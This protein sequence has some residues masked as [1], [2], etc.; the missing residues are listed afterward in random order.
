LA[1]GTYII[2]EAVVTKVATYILTVLMICLIFRMLLR[3]LSGVHVEV[4]T[5]VLLHV[6]KLE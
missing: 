1:A 2:G 6:V 4:R 5:D 3:R